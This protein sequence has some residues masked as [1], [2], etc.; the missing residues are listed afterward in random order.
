MPHTDESRRRPPHNVFNPPSRCKECGEFF[1]F[2]N[3]APVGTKICKCPSK[4]KEPGAT[5]IAK[6]RKRQIEVE[7]WDAEHDE[8]HTSMCLATAGA[9]YALD[10]VSKHAEVSKGWKEIFKQRSI[11]LWPFDEEW[12]RPTPDDPVRQL[13]KAGALIAAEIDRIQAK[14]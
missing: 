5:L 7:G 14:K 8:D 6:E 12:F 13:V 1:K 3:H 4:Y 10:V 9:S 11:E 2:P